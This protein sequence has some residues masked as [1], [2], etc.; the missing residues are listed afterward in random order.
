MPAI[1]EE[2]EEHLHSVKVFARLTGRYDQLTSKLDYLD[3]YGAKGN[4]QRTRCTLWLCQ[5]DAPFDFSFLIQWKPPGGGY[6]VE[7]PGIMNGGLVFHG[8]D[9]GWGIH[10]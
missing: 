6:A 3:T 8:G 2:T 4:I 7:R 9:N 1:P 5:Y 10:T